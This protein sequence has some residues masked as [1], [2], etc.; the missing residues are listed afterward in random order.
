M[1]TAKKEPSITTQIDLGAVSKFDTQGSNLLVRQEINVV[2]VVEFL[3]F[4][5]GR[6]HLDLLS[7]FDM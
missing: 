1:V 3:N 6:T 4:H 5:V 7:I 2:L